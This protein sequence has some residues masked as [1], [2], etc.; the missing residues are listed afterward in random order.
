[1]IVTWLGIITCPRR[2]F[3]ENLAMLLLAWTS[4][5]LP[6]GHPA[7]PSVYAAGD[8]LDPEGT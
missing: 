1:M 7:L 8:A 4:W 2:S 3:R 6:K 5:A